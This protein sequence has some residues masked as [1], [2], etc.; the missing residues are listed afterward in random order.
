MALLAK[1]WHPNDKV[2]HYVVNHGFPIR[3]LETKELWE[4]SK[5]FSRKKAFGM[6]GI[7]F[8]KKRIVFSSS[9]THSNNFTWQAAIIYHELVHVAQQRTFPQKWVGFMTTYLGQWIR[10]GFSYEKMKSFGIEKEAYA[11]QRKFVQSLTEKIRRG[12]T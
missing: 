5:F 12:L 3:G 11:L 10:S 7:T 6:S 1:R 2:E 4:S 9:L 8:H